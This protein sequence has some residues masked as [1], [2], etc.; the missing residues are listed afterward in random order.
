M[1]NYLFAS[2]YHELFPILLGKVD[3]LLFDSKLNGHVVYWGCY[4]L[5]DMPLG[6]LVYMTV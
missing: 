4:H 6:E 5:N 3:I 1:Y 2:L